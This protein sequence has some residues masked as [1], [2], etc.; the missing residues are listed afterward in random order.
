MSASLSDIRRHYAACASGLGLTSVSEL[1][2]SP[3]DE[4]IPQLAP[5]DRL[6]ALEASETATRRSLDRKISDNLSGASPAALTPAERF[7]LHHRNLFAADFLARLEDSLPDGSPSPLSACSPEWQTTLR[8]CSLDL[9][10]QFCPYWLRIL[11]FELDPMRLN[12][13]S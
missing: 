5:L 7:W 8:W 2:L 12:Q 10:H 1:R 6:R 4:D 11:A 9:W 3:G 13:P